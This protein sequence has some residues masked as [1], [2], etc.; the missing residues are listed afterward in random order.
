M[1]YE[2][3]IKIIKRWIEEDKEDQEK[4]LEEEKYDAANYYIGK[5]QAYKNVIIL[6]RTSD[7]INLPWES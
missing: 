2:E 1:I 5:V 7:E 6:L 3:I 4:L